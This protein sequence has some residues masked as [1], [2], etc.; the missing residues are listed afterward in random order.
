METHLQQAT[1]QLDGAVRD[2]STRLRC[3]C[4]CPRTDILDPH[5]CD[6]REY[7][8]VCTETELALVLL[9]LANIEESKKLLLMAV[10]SSSS[11]HSPCI[12]ES[13]K[14]A[15]VDEIV[16]HVG[17]LIDYLHILQ[18]AFPN[19][20][21]DPKVEFEHVCG[22]DAL[23]LKNAIFDYVAHICILCPK[24]SVA[25][26]CI[27]SALVSHSNICLKSDVVSDRMYQLLEFENR[28]FPESSHYAWIMFKT[29]IPRIA[30]QTLLETLQES[31]QRTT[32]IVK[33]LVLRFVDVF[34]AFL[35][36]PADDFVCYIQERFG[37]ALDPPTTT[38]GSTKKLFA[39]SAFFIFQSAELHTAE[40]AV[41][42]TSS[43]VGFFDGSRDGKILLLADQES[44]RYAAW[45]TARVHAIRLRAVVT[46]LRSLYDTVHLQTQSRAPASI[47]VTITATPDPQESIEF[48]T[49]FCDFITCTG[50]VL[51]KQRF[52][53]SKEYHHSFFY[54]MLCCNVV[55]HIPSDLH[56]AII[57]VSQLAC[58]LAKRFLLC[59][60]SQ[61][62]TV[63][64][65]SGS[66]CNRKLC[67][68]AAVWNCNRIV[69]VGVSDKPLLTGRHSR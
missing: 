33:D 47:V 55:I 26:E 64:L 6:I 17:K 15:T 43:I 63:S 8:H 21:F 57:C 39:L 65:R 11:L 4:V 41:A 56:G 51:K 34:D 46:V 12:F 40:S 19:T 10:S 16:D 29:G 2:R 36:S 30:N 23:S 22:E 9:L 50:G 32:G 20:L 61:P 31:V 27:R 68:N 1:S 66:H 54:D 53:T 38:C 59:S 14:V 58:T 62:G 25:C 45:D 67:A 60:S 35:T 18:S 5:P 7:D 3:V 48:A 42:T 49:D 44:M 13:D 24:E 37:T 69:E 28:E 52:G